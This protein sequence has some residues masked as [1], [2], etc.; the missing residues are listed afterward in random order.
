[1][2]VIHYAKTDSAGKKRKNVHPHPPQTNKHAQPCRALYS[3]CQTYPPK[4]TMSETSH[5]KGCQR[6]KRWQWFI[7]QNIAGEEE[8][9][10]VTCGKNE[11][12]M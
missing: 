10:M 12:I 11:D 9:I 6:C 1:V 5:L 7:M 2:A 4:V 8:N 3:A